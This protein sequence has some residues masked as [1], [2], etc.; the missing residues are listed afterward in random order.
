MA[1]RRRN[2]RTEERYRKRTP[3]ISHCPALC[4]LPGKM[5]KVLKM[6]MVIGYGCA[7]SILFGPATFTPGNALVVLA[8]PALMAGYC[9]YLVGVERSAGSS[10]FASC[11]TCWR[12]VRLTALFPGRDHVGL[13]LYRGDAEPLNQPTFAGFRFQPGCLRPGNADS[14]RSSTTN[15]PFGTSRRVRSLATTDDQPATGG[16]RYIS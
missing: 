1:L 7:L 5:R 16:R 9:A 6:L 8:V 3:Y 11:G 14:E 12:R 15:Q 2:Y 10:H 13:R 4:C